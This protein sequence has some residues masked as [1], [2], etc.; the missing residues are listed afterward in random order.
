[1]I[2][3]IAAIL[4]MS[5]SFLNMHL[6]PRLQTYGL[7]AWLISDVILIWYL[8]NISVW[9]TLMYGFYCGTCLYGIWVRSK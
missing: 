4:G 1:M 2:D 3:I 7:T 8:W 5:G 9:I 6:S